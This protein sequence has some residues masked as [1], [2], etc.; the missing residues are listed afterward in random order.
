MRSE[1]L[2]FEK[3]TETENNSKSDRKISLFSDETPSFMQ[4]FEETKKCYNLIL[5]Q[6]LL[7]NNS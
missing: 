2:D 6:K 4:Q 3:L 1:T 7:F 5:H